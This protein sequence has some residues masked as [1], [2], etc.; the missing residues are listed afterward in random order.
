ME[1]ISDWLDMNGLADRHSASKG[2][3]AAA[4]ENSDWQRN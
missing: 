4:V 3:R 1:E 2:I